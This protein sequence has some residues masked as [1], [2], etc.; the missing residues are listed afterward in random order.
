MRNFSD[1]QK[2]FIDAKALL[3]TTDKAMYDSVMK[4]AK[5]EK[6]DPCSEDKKMIDRYI[7]IEMEVED[8]YGYREIRD[9]YKDSFWKLLSWTIEKMREYDAKKAEDL[10]VLLKKESKVFVWGRHEKISDLC[11]NLNV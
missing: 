5:S 11:L 2:A 4:R 3:E 9:L 1:E 8:L 6:I 7:E 10:E